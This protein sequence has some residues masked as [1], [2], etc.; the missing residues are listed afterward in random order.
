[1]A[2]AKK[3]LQD[4]SFWLQEEGFSEAIV[5]IFKGVLT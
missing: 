1:M 5:E 4:T 2:F 3:M